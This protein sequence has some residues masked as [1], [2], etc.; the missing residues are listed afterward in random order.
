MLNNN[1]TICLSQKMS[2][3]WPAEFACPP[4]SIAQFCLRPL[5]RRDKLNMS[6]PIKGLLPLRSMHTT[7]SHWI[8]CPSRL[9]QEATLLACQLSKPGK[10][11]LYIGIFDSIILATSFPCDNNSPFASKL[12]CCKC[13]LFFPLTFGTQ[14][15]PLLE[16]MS[17]SSEYFP[18]DD[19]STTFLKIFS[20]RVLFHSVLS[21]SSSTSLSSSESATKSFTVSAVISAADNAA[22]SL[23]NWDDDDFSIFS[24]QQLQKI[25]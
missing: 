4:A 24:P 14:A 7:Q 20:H 11:S 10:T 13:L 19:F 3:K 8:E 16:G 15:L 23:R 12:A 17:R 22:C 9:C 18:W 2:S 6:L 21:G 25:K 5:D 1:S